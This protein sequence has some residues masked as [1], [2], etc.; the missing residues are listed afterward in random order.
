MRPKAPL[1]LALAAA[2]ASAAAAHAAGLAFEG[3][4][5]GLRVRPLEP[6]GVSGPGTESWRLH[7]FRL[8]AGAAPVASA[9]IGLRPRAAHVSTYYP[10]SETIGSS[11]EASVT[12]ET[13]FA[14]RRYAMQGQVHT[15][16]SASRGLS[17]GLRLRH[18]EPEAES[19][20]PLAAS[21]ALSP[22]RVPGGSFATSYQLQLSYRYSAAGTLGL[23]LGRDLET[24][25]PG[26]E[27]VPYGLRQF[28][29]TGQH[30]LSP[31]WA[32]SYDLLAEEPGSGLRLQGLRLGVRYR[33]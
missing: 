10:F 33:F 16:L 25:T 13:L 4:G 19:A 7:P 18:Y 32:L 24:F 9:G 15:A 17:V 27:T 5:V 26:F 2:L 1:F 22:W 20:G 23:A 14:P 21:Y 3:S 6:P 29:L 30:W 8:D 28:T 12:P 11:L 31:S